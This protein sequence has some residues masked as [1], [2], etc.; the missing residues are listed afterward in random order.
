MS[1]KD[2]VVVVSLEQVD[3]SVDS[4]DI[5]LISTAGEKAVKD[6]TALEDIK[7]DWG[8]TSDMYK[9]A[10]Q[11]MGQG[12]ARTRKEICILFDIR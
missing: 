4:L 11:M 9:M 2:V 10:A 7:T 8:E 1:S 3:T 6:Y 5:L 12:K